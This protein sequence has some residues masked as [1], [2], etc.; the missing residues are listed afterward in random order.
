MLLSGL[1]ALSLMFKLGIGGCYYDCGSLL[2][3]CLCFELLLLCVFAYRGF[4][5]ECLR[6]CLGIMVLLIAL[7]VQL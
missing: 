1:N 2:F 5:S 3:W 6:G 7:Y 4:V